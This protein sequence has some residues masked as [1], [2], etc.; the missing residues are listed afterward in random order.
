MPKEPNRGLLVFQGHSQIVCMHFY[1]LLGMPS[2]MFSTQSPLYWPQYDRPNS[3]QEPDSS[4]VVVRHTPQKRTKN[5]KTEYQCFNEAFMH[6]LQ[7]VGWNQN[8]GVVEL[9]PVVVG[10]S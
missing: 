9:V 7:N 5:D 10:C 6:K 3:V 2:S 4:V 1:S 8:Y